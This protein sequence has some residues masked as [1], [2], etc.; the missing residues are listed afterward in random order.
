M[1]E[2]I[3]QLFSFMRL[4]SGKELEDGAMYR[5]SLCV[6]V[7][8]TQRSRRLCLLASS[9]NFDISLLLAKSGAVLDLELLDSEIR[10]SMQECVHSVL[11]NSSSHRLESC[12]VK[13]AS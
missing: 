1:I 4:D 13:K 7:R 8:C 2:R 12:Q 11:A 9:H 3:K 5:A 6:S 10:I